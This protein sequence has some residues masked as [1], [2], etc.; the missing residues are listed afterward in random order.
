ML[1]PE[2]FR[3]ATGVPLLMN[4]LVAL[5]VCRVLLMW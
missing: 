1:R 5:K 2:E 3:V 4:E